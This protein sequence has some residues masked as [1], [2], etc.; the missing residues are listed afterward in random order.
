M[1]S[2]IIYLS[3]TLKIYKIFWKIGKIQLYLTLV[4][5]NDPGGA[6]KE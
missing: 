5:I 4:L 3:Y 6:W 1:L 2:E